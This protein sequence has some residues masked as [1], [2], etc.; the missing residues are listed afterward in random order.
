MDKHIKIY[1]LRC[2]SSLS[3][4]GT[5]ECYS[6]SPWANAAGYSGDDDGGAL[7]SVPDGVKV[8]PARWATSPSVGAFNTQ[9]NIELREVGMDLCPIGTLP[10]SIERGKKG[11]YLS[12]ATPSSAPTRKWELNSLEDDKALLRGLFDS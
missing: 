12:N 4:G 2:W 6:L 1:K 7:Y 11:P 8:F 5:G 10:L 9:Q 3:G